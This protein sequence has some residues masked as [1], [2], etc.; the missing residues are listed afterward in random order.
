MVRL[1][2][3]KN[4]EANWKPQVDGEVGS[5]GGVRNGEDTESPVTES[6][7]VGRQSYRGEGQSVSGV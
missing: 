3:V 6:Q 1:P 5:E 7:E 4:L 2:F